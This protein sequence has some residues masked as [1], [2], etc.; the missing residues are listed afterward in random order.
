[1]D[2]GPIAPAASPRRRLIILGCLWAFIALVLVVFRS[3]VLP[4]AAAGLIAYLVAPLVERLTHLPIGRW[5]LPRWSAILFIYVAF[6]FAVYLASIALLPQL[7]R[8][9]ARISRDAV[10]W[11][12]S[13]TPERVQELSET[14]EDWLSARGVPVDMSSRSLEG[15]HSEEESPWASNTI[16]AP[17]TPERAAFNLSVDLDQVLKSAIAKGGAVARENFGDIVEVSRRVI[18]S[19]LAGVFMLFFMLMVAAFFSIDTK[20]IS[21]YVSTLIPPEHASDVRTLG[22]MIDRKLAGVVRG[23][24]T[25]C[26][27][28]GVLTFIGLFIL[29][30]KF[31]FLLATIA[32]FLSLIPIF[33]TIL[34]SIPIVLIGLSQSWKAG[35]AALLWIIVI[36]ALEAYFLNPRIMG[37][38]ARIHPIVVAFSLIAGERMFGLIGALFAVPLAA[39]VV[40]CF[41]FW[42]LKAQPPQAAAQGVVA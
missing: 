21:S 24:I 41:D 22:R 32:T 12:N 28:N 9:L 2:D 10:A 26:L 5:R 4:F 6:F 20:A 36:H 38:A 31:A 14:L 8:E 25:I 33:G 39:V 16:P 15:A 19:V 30:I 11:S 17:D 13:L 7:Y 29:G 34:S 23:Q 27:V 37:T 42:R 35:L 3:V 1:M 40:A 18:T